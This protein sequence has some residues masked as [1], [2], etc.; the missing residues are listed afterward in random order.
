MTKESGGNLSRP[1]DVQN[2][3]R[4]RIAAALGQVEVVLDGWDYL[5]DTSKWLLADAVIAAL[6]T[7]RCGRCRQAVPLDHF[8]D[9]HP[10]SDEMRPFCAV[11]TRYIEWATS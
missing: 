7:R 4:D 11:C 2:L 10:G 5:N 8:P 9:P 1:G 3:L 6:G